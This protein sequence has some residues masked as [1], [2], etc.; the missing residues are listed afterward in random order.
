[1]TN[2]SQL[3]ALLDRAVAGWTRRPNGWCAVGS[4][5]AGAC[6]GVAA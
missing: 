6:A 2:D 1:M 4:S 5:A 3:T